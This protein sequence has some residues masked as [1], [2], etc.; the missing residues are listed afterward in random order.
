[1][2][3]SA[4][5]LT[6][7]SLP[8]PGVEIYW[9]SLPAGTTSITVYRLAEG[10]SEVVRSG[11]QASAS[12][13]FSI[14]DFEA[15]LGTPIVYSAETYISGVSDGFSATS[16]ITIDTEAIAIQ[17]P[18]NPNNSVSVLLGSGGDFMLGTEAFSSISRPTQITKSMVIGRAKPV[19]QFYG[20]KGIEG[21]EFDVLVDNSQYGKFNDVL[22]TQPLLIRTP[23]RMGNLPRSLF[24][25]IQA[26]EL[27]LDWGDA[28]GSGLTR[29]T[30]TADEVESQSRAI[31]VNV[32]TYAAYT[33]KYLTYTAAAAVYGGNDYTNLN[34]NPLA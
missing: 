12:G 34:R 5:V 19:V 3:A 27:P 21:L 2:A 24:V 30:L 13:S 4:P 7:V 33:A 28:N 11:L 18:L 32:F 6:Q 15:P 1:M 10:V 9:S 16:T 20:R 31:V 25:T 26:A 8:V 23:G 29:F 22:D 17:D 14:T